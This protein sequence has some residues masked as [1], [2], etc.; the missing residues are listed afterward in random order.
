MDS[1][2]KHSVLRI[3]SFRIV[4]LAEIHSYRSFRREMDEA[5]AGGWRPSSSPDRDNGCTS[6]AASCS[7][8]RRTSKDPV[9]SVRL[10]SKQAW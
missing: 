4:C 8:D 5:G 1:K 7:G 10:K 2:E 3:S 9:C 6:Q